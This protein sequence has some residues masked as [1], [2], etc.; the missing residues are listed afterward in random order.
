MCVLAWYVCIPAS[1]VP[2]SRAADD[3]L[4]SCENVQR[5]CGKSRSTTDAGK[6]S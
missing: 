6:Q 3:V 1:V 4:D 5:S 2:R